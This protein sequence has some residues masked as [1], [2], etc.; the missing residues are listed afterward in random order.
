MARKRSAFLVPQLVVFGKVNDIPL[1]QFGI[2]L[3]RVAVK[4]EILGACRFAHHDNGQSFLPGCYRRQRLFCIEAERSGDD[5]VWLFQLAVADISRT[6]PLLRA[7]HQLFHDVGAVFMAHRGEAVVIGADKR[8]CDGQ[9]DDDR[10]STPE[11]SQQR[12]VLA[13]WTQM[14]KERER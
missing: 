1:L 7:G 3:T 6:V 8:D 4:A 14:M 2:G 11:A 13:T 12:P 5:S 9:A 10:D